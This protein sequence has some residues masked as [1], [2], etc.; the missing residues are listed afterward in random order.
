VRTQNS[1]KGRPRK[2]IDQGKAKITFTGKAVTS[3]AGMA[4]ISRALEHF[5]VCED[6]QQLSADLDV[7]KHHPMRSLWEQLIAIRM[8]GGEAIS[9][10]AMLK[11]SA[12][13]AF[14]E[15]GGIAHPAT[16]GRRLGEM[17]WSHNLGLERIVTGLSERVCQS[18]QRLVAI[19]STVVSVFGE[20]IEGAERGYNPHKPGRDS[21]HP[22]LAV[23]VAARAV[24]DGY[25][26]PGSC[27]TAHGLD[28]FIRKL[29]AESGH[30]V[31]E[32]V[33][34]LDKGLTSGAVLDTLEGL[35]AG[36]VAKLK[37]S[38]TVAGKIS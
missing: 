18:G 3:H 32:T 1:K 2:V 36:Y 11:D 35:G 12:L 31:E 24:V 8:M 5:S 15:W 23:D 16:F 19:D 33:F 26:R 7:G 25:L 22:L 34:R 4:L 27:G 20:K 37:L 21:Y 14:F 6:L 13:S 9:D 28:G 10:T 30:L 17:R 29:V 38:P